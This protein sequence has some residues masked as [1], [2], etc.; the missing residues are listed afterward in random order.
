[1]ITASEADQAAE[2]MLTAY[3]RAA[4][5]S[6]PEEVRK[7]CEMM[8]SKAARAVEKYNGVAVTV[9]VLE[10]T[11]RNIKASPQQKH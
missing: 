1:M 8:I 7:V 3:C 2:L 6:T 10:R 5:C 9:E 11:A 4:G